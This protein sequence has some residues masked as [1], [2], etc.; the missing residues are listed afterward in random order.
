MEAPIRQGARHRRDQAALHMKCA[1]APNRLMFRRTIA[2]IAASAA[3]AFFLAA[4]TS[5][6]R[7]SA[8]C[9]AVS[10]GRRRA[11][12]TCRPCRCRSCFARLRAGRQS[13]AVRHDAPAGSASRPPRHLPP[14]RSW[15]GFPDARPSW[16][17][18]HCRSDRPGLRPPRRPPQHPELRPPS[19]RRQGLTWSPVQACSPW[20]ALPKRCTV[21][22]PVPAPM[23]GPQ[24]GK[25]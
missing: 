4:R 1:Q 25:M 2:S 22:P 3:A 8:Y 7:R 19:D 20:P 12:F 21:H 23:H 15:P 14:H 17:Q 13:L 11:I 5:V 24:I 9:A 18:A 6:S 16:R 10:N